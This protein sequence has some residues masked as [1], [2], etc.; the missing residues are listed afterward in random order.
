MHRLASRGAQEIRLLSGG[1]N[2]RPHQYSPD[3]KLIVYGAGDPKTSQD[4]MLLSIDAEA[5]DRKPMPLLNSR[6]NEMH[7]QLSPDQK[8]I[9]YTSDSSGRREIYV[10]SFPA[11]DSVTTMS[12][13]GGQMQR[14][15]RDGKELFFISR[16]L[17]CGIQEMIPKPVL[18][19]GFQGTYRVTGDRIAADVVAHTNPNNEGNM[20]VRKITVE[21][22]TLT[23]SATN[24]NVPA[25]NRYRRIRNAVPPGADKWACAEKSRR[26]VDEHKDLAWDATCFCQEPAGHELFR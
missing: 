9:A 1:I 25:F 15:R 5:K 17:E 11:G 2:L 14:W 16:E 26:N 3:G 4:L 21:G 12:I 7:G 8:W 6:F 19:I 13:D 24:P 18:N 10:Q 22:D 20:A 23:L